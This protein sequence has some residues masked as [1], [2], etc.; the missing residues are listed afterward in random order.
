MAFLDETGAKQL[1]KKIIEKA[2]SGAS[3]SRNYSTYTKTG[4]NQYVTAQVNNN[5]QTGILYSWIPTIDSIAGND[6]NNLCGLMSLDSYNDLNQLTTLVPHTLSSWVMIFYHENNE[7]NHG[8]SA[9]GSPIHIQFATGSSTNCSVR[10]YIQPV[11]GADMK[12][13]GRIIAEVCPYEKSTVTITY[14]NKVARTRTTQYP[15]KAVAYVD[16]V[17]GASMMINVVKSA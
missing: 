2:G 6:S 14:N 12:D 4:A 1:A 7:I 3:A 16:Y 8:L 5:V 17:K 11:G 15:N 10:V 13:Y 9:S